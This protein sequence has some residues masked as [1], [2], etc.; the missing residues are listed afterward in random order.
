MTPEFSREAARLMQ[1]EVFQSLTL[2]QRLDV[3]DEV[4]GE[5]SFDDLSL[6]SQTLFNEARKELAGE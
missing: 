6:E 4:A 1:A 5:E 2:D 3:A